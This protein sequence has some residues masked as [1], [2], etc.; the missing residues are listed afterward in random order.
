M[1]KK[2]NIQKRVINIKAIHNSMVIKYSN[3]MKWMFYK[4]CLIYH[5]CQK[6][7]RRRTPNPV[8]IKETKAHST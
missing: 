8:T 1:M 3:I 2:L 5:N 7:K 4:Q 6:K